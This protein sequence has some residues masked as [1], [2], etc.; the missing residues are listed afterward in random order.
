MRTQTYCHIMYLAI[1]G[2]IWPA[3]GQA[4]FRLYLRLYLDISE[5]CFLVP[6]RPSPLARAGSA[7][8]TCSP[9]TARDVHRAPRAIASE[10]GVCSSALL[11]S[12]RSSWFRPNSAWMSTDVTKSSKKNTKKIQP[13]LARTIE[14]RLVANTGRKCN[15]RQI[16]RKYERHQQENT[17]NRF[18]P[19]GRLSLGY[20]YRV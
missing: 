18:F 15:L 9:R 8:R 7:R 6:R 14:N 10:A 1:F 17:N 20:R 4:A 5:P 19:L 11:S 2:C 13:A 3:P 12:Q 16:W